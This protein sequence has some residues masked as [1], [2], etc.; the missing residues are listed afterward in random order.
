M[1]VWNIT[2]KTGNITRDFTGDYHI[3]LIAP[4]EEQGNMEP[5]NKLLNDEKRLKSAR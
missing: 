2:V 1:I 3:T 5:L 4:K